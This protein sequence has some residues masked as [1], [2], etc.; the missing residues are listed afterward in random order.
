[1]AG[2]GE[3]GV[4]SVIGSSASFFEKVWEDREFIISRRKPGWRWSGPTTGCSISRVA[5]PGQLR[6]SSASLRAEK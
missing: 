1:M 4:H 6:S 2:P 3:P 5:T